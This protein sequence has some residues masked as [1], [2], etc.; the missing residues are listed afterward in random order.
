MIC[1]QGE[2]QTF[3]GGPDGYARQARTTTAPGARTGLWVPQIGR[4]LVAAR[5]EGGMGA[6]LLVLGP[7]P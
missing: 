2:V 5:A 4:L 6:R 7:A 1:G 3:V